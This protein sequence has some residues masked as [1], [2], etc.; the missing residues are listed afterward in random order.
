MWIN[1]QFSDLKYQ[2][3]LFSGQWADPVESEHIAL[4]TY[5]YANSSLN[6][7]LLRRT[8]LLQV[9]ARA[10]SGYYFSML[11]LSIL[12]TVLRYLLYSFP[13]PYNL[14]SFDIEILFFAGIVCGSHH[15]IL[16]N[17]V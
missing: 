4:N 12:R 1:L 8:L 15:T 11:L 16:E 7:V 5:I 6:T 10:S 3:N 2:S 13:I 9:F 14:H 17:V